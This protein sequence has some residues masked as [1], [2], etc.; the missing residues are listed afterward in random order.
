MPT[1]TRRWLNG[2]KLTS[3]SE[4]LSVRIVKIK[5]VTRVRFQPN[6]VS[7]G[8][9][10]NFVSCELST[11]LSGFLCSAVVLPV[12]WAVVP[13]SAITVSPDYFSRLS[14]LVATYSVQEMSKARS[15]HPFYKG[16]YVYHNQSID[17]YHLLKAGIVAVES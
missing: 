16:S 4:R 1:I 2:G 13:C 8:D 11:P 15:G 6:S 5:P 17:W 12:G 14:I 9:A 7:V 3:R 10:H